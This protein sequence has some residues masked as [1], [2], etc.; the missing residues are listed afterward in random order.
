M[1]LCECGCG[2]PAPLAQQT[3]TKRGWVAN[4]P[5]R[6]ISGHNVRR[7]RENHPGWKGGEYHHSSGRILLYRPN[8]PRAGQTGY[9]FRSLL[10]AEKALGRPVP[11]SVIIHHIDSNVGDDSPYNLVICQDTAYHWLLHVRQR[12]YNACGNAN[13]RKC[14]ICKKYDAVYNLR[15][16]QYVSGWEYRHN[17]RCVDR[18][19]AT[20]YPEWIKKLKRIWGHGQDLDKIISDIT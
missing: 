19:K 3:N 6:F 13:Y 14:I 2:E 5:L 16:N 15:K 17:Y 11:V 9:V 7:K 8:H 4:K 12:A 1:K 20:N 10:V 18:A